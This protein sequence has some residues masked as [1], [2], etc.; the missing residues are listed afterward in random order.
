MN[1]ILV[2][3]S[4]GFIGQ[5]LV[6][7]LLNDKRKVFLVTSSIKS[8]FPLKKDNILLIGEWCKTNLS[9]DFLRKYK[10]YLMH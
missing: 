2:T 3:G 7:N 10:F 1:K 4:T 8:L 5:S 9:N 6:N